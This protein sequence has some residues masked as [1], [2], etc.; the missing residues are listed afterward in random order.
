MTQRARAVRAQAPARAGIE[1]NFAFLAALLLADAHRSG[2][3]PQHQVGDL[4]IHRLAHAQPGLKHHLNQGI[5]T[6]P[7]SMRRLAG[8]VKE[9]LN[10]R[11]A[12][13]LGA[14]APHRAREFDFSGDIAFEF[15]L[16]V[17]PSAETAQGF[18]PAVETGG[19]QSLFLRQVLAVM[20]QIDGGELLQL[21][22]RV[23]VEK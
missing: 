11:I 13:A 5:V 18:E 4:E 9:R 1:R 21:V 8:G 19:A 7:Q 17:R 14:N 12:Q 3:F 23:P 20:D 22:R 6:L 16:F 15:L 2:A 10:F